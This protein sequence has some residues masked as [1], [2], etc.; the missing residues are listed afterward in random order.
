MNEDYYINVNDLMEN[1]VDEL[2]RPTV[3][4]IYIPRGEDEQYRNTI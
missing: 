3:K 4:I 1:M 2:P